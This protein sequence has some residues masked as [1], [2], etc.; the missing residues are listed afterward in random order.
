[1]NAH[2][3]HRF[4]A[5]PRDD[6]QTVASP[7]EVAQVIERMLTDLRAH[8][9]AW[10][11]STLERF[12]DSLARCLMAQPQLYANLGQQYPATAEWRLFAEALVAAS[13]YE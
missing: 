12:L 1:M 11:N 6:L 2:E 4:A 13:G 10:E 8:P 9:T 7:A 3:T 5:V